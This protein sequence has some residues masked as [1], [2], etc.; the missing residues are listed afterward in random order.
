MGVGG[1]G[2]KGCGCYLEAEYGCGWL[3][4]F[5]MAGMLGMEVKVR[6]MK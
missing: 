6:S 1:V 2:V 4:G 5:R 3:V